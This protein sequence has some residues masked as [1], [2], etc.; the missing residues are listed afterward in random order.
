LGPFSVFVCRSSELP[1]LRDYAHGKIAENTFARKER[2]MPSRV[3]PHS[4][5]TLHDLLKRLGGISPKRIR[6][7]PP[8]GTATEK[9][10]IA[11]QNRTDRLYELVEGVLVEKVVGHLESTLT[12]DLIKLLGYYLD[13]NDVGFLAG[14]DG[15]TRLTLGLVRAPDVSLILWEQLPTRERPTQPIASI[16]PAL[17]VEILSP[18]NTKKEIA[19]KIREYFLSGVRLVWVIDPKQRTLQVYTAPDKS[20]VLTEAQTLT[21]GEVLPGFMLP[22]RKLFAAVPRSL[23]AAKTKKNKR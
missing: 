13:Q 17:A 8:P 10:V 15:A 6:V 18:G 20:V 1:L 19:R 11:I 3:K 14:P 5:E 7:D 12:C 4:D 9:D 2:A 21:G 16:D 22:L 23:S